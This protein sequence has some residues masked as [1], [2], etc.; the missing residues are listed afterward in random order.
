MT[1]ATRP[2][3]IWLDVLFKKLRPN[4]KYIVYGPKLIADTK[5]SAAPGRTLKDDD[6]IYGRL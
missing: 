1:P 5:L 4:L 6:V 2:I 3:S